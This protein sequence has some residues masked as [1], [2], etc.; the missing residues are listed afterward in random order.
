M[1]GVHVMNVY[2]PAYQEFIRRLRTARKKQGLTQI[3]AGKLLK[4]PHSYISK[5]ESG[6]RRV[7]VIEALQFAK[8]YKKNI[9]YFTRNIKI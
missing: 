9:L 1:L 6:E 2:H 5:C 8:I 7:T 4:K 3:E